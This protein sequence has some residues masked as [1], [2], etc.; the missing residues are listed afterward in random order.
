MKR[1]LVTGGLGFLGSAIVRELRDRGVSVRALA[2]RGEKRDNLK[3][4]EVE[5]VEGDVRSPSDCAR[6]VEGQDTVFHCAAIYADWAP[7]PT[8]MYEV[9]TKGTFHVLEA[10]RRA[11]VE[12]VI[13]TA[14]I[15]SLGRPP[16]GTLGDERT[17]YQTWDLDFPYSRS[18]YHSRVIAESFA[19]WGLDVRVVCPGVVFGPNDIRPTP[20]GMLIVSSIKTPGPATAFEGGMSY[21]DVRDAAR[22]HVLAAEKGKAGERYI[23]S[24]HNL[25]NAQLLRTIDAVTA[26]KRP[27]V[28]LPIAMARAI[29]AGMERVAL[30]TGKPPLLSRDFLEYALQPGYYDNGKSI[31]ELGASYRPIEETIRDAVAY[32][33]ETGRLR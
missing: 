23:A 4:I 15:V 25:D 31:R 27:V 18:K 2:A 26:R 14:S 24:A 17:A 30:R 22:V 32:F 10:A 29:A 8:L 16:K 1:A 3:G 33:E 13:Y 12:K 11:G 28:T 20:S 6:A 9:N 21:V 7:D 5:V 19:E